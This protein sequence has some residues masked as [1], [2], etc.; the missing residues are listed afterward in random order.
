MT[1]P[2]CHTQHCSETCKDIGL[3]ITVQRARYQGLVQ[4]EEAV[5]NELLEK[6]KAE[7]AQQEQPAVQFDTEAAVEAEEQQ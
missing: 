4:Y 5:L 7:S 6:A 1:R 2:S 3:N